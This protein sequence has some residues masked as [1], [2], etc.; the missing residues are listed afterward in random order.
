[1]GLSFFGGLAWLAALFISLVWPALLAWL[2]WRWQASRI[3]DRGRFLIR[4]IPI[5]YAVILGLHLLLGAWVRSGA[6]Q[7]AAS[8]AW[9]DAWGPLLAVL[10]IENGAAVFALHRLQLRQRLAARRR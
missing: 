6:E 5:S 9:F 7:Y 10:L 4:A 3:G 2:Y 8:G 1:M